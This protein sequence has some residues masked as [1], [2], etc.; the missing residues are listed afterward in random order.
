MTRIAI[1][2]DLHLPDR[3]D[4]I[5][6]R[7]LDWALAECQRRAVSL[8]GLAG[9][10]TSMGTELAA[11][12]FRAKLEAA[13]IPFIIALGNAELRTPGQTQAVA[14]HFTTPEIMQNVV[15][16]DSS[17]IALSSH[18]RSF[19]AGIVQGEGEP[20]A[21]MTHCPLSYLPAE[22]QKLLVQ[23]MDSGRISLLV[24]AHIHKDRS[25]LKQQN[26]RG[27]DP[28]KAIGGPSA[29]FIF[30]DATGAWTRTDVPCPM[31]DLATWSQA[32][33]TEFLSF[34]GISGMKSTVDG[35]KSAAEHAIPSFEIRA[36]VCDGAVKE[37]DLW[38]SAG[39]K[40]LSCHLASFKS[41]EEG[42]AEVASSVD[43][44]LKCACQ[45]ATMHVP[46]YA[47]VAEMGRPDFFERTLLRYAKHLAPLAAAGVTIGIENLH[48]HQGEPVDE[49]RG[50]G[51]TP[52]E[53]RQWVEAVK[54][55][56][57]Y[58]GVGFHFDI[59]HA[60]NNR[61][62]ASLYNLSEW[63]AVLGGLFTGCHLHQVA[64]IDGKNVNHSPF[65]SLYAP[66]VPL[67]GFL[68]AWRERSIKHVP[69]YLEIRSDEP[70][71]S[72]IFLEDKIK[73]DFN[74]G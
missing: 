55:R 20:V 44:C 45:Y 56:M 5:K 2:A 70:V 35:L 25:N 66:Y 48:L 46:F 53:Y 52:A 54:E 1:L 26:V 57:G 58:Q 60:R 49:N 63:Y 59:G 39:G 27:M 30:D 62:L 8:I 50:Y 7:V 21:A 6:E 36:G 34:L 28:D 42:D 22:D 24:T 29:I 72:Y 33:R 19:L 14:R 23:G 71:N 47:T 18:S 16:L 3:D 9:D 64:P 69:M 15:A 4:T 43:L 61:I 65:A 41:A 40:Y 31:A 12:R 74:K 38:R 13:G 10:M 32:V 37:L 17:K 73:T 51:Y 67:G 68:M 11:S